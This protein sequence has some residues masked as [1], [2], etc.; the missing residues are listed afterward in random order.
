[1]RR[2]IYRGQHLELDPDWVGS[3]EV[4]VDQSDAWDTTIGSDNVWLMDMGRPPAWLG[5]AMG[6]QRAFR[7]SIDDPHDRDV[8]DAIGRPGALNPSPPTYDPTRQILVHFD[9]INRGVVAHRYE[10]GAPP[11][12][13]WEQPLRNLTQMIVWLDTGELALEDSS[14]PSSLARD[15]SADAVLVE[16][17]TGSEIGRAPIGSA[18][19]TGMF[20]S[21]GFARDFYVC[22]IAGTVARVYVE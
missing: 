19:T 8:I 21:P 14:S 3:Y 11:R 10:R 1:M 9:S 12:L 2:L 15:P 6:S 13:L 18:A 4:S 5:R 7:F 20:C 17:E 22:S 16:I